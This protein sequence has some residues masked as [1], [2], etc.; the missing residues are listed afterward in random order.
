M[1]INRIKRQKN[2]IKFLVSRIL[3]HSGLCRLFTIEFNSRIKIRFYPTAGSASFWVEP[4][5]CIDEELFITNY[6]QEGD[7]FI[8]VGANI[9]YITLTAAKKIGNAGQVISI[10]PHPKT[11]SFLKRNIAFNKFNNIKTY[12]VAIGNESGR[13]SFTNSKSDEQNFI[14]KAGPVEVQIKKLDEIF[15]GEHVD[16]LKIDTEGYEL[17]VLEGAQEVL[18]KVK[19][20]YLE[21]YQVHFDRYNYDSK[22]IL[23]FLTALNF[24]IYTF[25]SAKTLKEIDY[26]SDTCL[27]K[28]ENIVAIKDIEFFKSRLPEY[29]IL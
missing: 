28:F 29:Q 20:I 8:D 3:W 26:S 10:E 9:G 1:F 24:K 19:V 16:F 23:S 25:Q 5:S 2:I 17:F 13:V 22:K 18:K 27:N 6:L 15:Q 4:Y 7:T 14:T 21:V 11:F 12:N